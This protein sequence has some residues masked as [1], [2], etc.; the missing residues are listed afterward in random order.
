MQINA[1]RTELAERT[2]AH[3]EASEFLGQAQAE[4][5]S[6]RGFRVPSQQSSDAGTAVVKVVWSRSSAASSVFGGDSPIAGLSSCIGGDV[7]I[8]WLH[9][10]GRV[11]ASGEMLR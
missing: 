10:G 2:R 4:M 1:S 7:A 3:N 5:E 9:H 11:A 6:L 8:G